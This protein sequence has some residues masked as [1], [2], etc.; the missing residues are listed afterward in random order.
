MTV[1]LEKTK[2]TT[3]EQLRDEHMPSLDSRRVLNAPKLNMVWDSTRS[4]APINHTLVAATAKEVANLDGSKEYLG[5][6]NADIHVLQGVGDAAI[7]DFYIPANTYFTV[8]GNEEATRLSIFSTI[9]GFVQFNE[10]RKD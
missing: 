1:E 6:S 3:E 8:K 4:Q 10:L 7:T 9:G 5:I 2:K